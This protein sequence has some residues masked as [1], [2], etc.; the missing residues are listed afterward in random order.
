MRPANRSYQLQLPAAPARSLSTTGRRAASK[1]S[2]PSAARPPLSSRARARAWA[3]SI[4]SRV[5][6]PMEKWTLRSASPMST[7]FSY[8]QRSQ[9]STGNRRHSERFEMSGRPPRSGA[10]TASQ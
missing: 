1:R 9:A 6:E 7:T 5:P 2:S 3:S 8:R 4:A 10:K